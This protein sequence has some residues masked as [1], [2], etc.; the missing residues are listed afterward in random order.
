MVMGNKRQGKGV[1]EGTI[2]DRKN[3]L[4]LLVIMFTKND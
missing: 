4:L 3:S 2:L 1:F